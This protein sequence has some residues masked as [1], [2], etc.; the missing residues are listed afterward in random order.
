MQCGQK[1]RKARS[2]FVNRHIN[3]IDDH[4]S[5]NLSR[6]RHDHNDVTCTHT[7]CTHKCVNVQRASRCSYS[8]ALHFKQHLH[9]FS[10]KCFK[11]NGKFLNACNASVSLIDI[12]LAYRHTFK[13]TAHLLPTGSLFIVCDVCS[14]PRDLRYTFSQ[15]L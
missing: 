13:M 5:C 8:L 4:T 12:V 7:A 3:V 9:V 10:L 15:Q 1:K 14:C 6:Q 11:M 2:D